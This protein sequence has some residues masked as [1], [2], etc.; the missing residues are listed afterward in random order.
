MEM[1]IVINEGEKILF[2]VYNVC[3]IEKEVR[4]LEEGLNDGKL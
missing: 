2:K 4:T 1:Q 3:R